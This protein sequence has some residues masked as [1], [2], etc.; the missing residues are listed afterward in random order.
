MRR[1]VLQRVSRRSRSPEEEEEGGLTQRV[2]DSSWGQDGGVYI[3]LKL[4]KLD[5]LSRTSDRSRSPE[6]EEELSN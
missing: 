2:L 5:R 6:E 1:V 3:A 4:L